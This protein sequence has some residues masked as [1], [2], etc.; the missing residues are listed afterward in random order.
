MAVVPLVGCK[1]EGDFFVFELNRRMEKNT[2]EIV[3]FKS[4]CFKY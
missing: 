4:R 3:N 2:K 1:T